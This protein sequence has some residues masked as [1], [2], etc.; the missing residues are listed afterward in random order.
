[1]A[2]LRTSIH[3]FLDGDLRDKCPP[4]VQARF[5]LSPSGVEFVGDEVLR[6]NSR[7]ES[8][9]GGLEQVWR[10]LEGFGLE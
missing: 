1:M 2:L 8:F 7:S 9:E 6:E 5:E 4:I 10:I 3:G